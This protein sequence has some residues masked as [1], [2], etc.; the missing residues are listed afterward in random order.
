MNI[1]NDSSNG[2]KPD[3][4]EKLRKILG[5]ALLVAVSYRF[6]L[7]RGSSEKTIGQY[8]AL[9]AQYDALGTQY[10]ALSAEYNR[11]NA[12]YSVTRTQCEASAAQYSALKAQ[13]DRIERRRADGSE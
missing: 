8:A 3:N 6:G 10:S 1:D 11:A 12:Q 5:L 4:G 7:E 13:Y 2:A 9:R